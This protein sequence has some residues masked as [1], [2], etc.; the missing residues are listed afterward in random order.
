MMIKAIMNREYGDIKQTILQ[1]THQEGLVGK[2]LPPWGDMMCKQLTNIQ[3]TH[4]PQFIPFLPNASDWSKC[5]GVRR[6]S[7]RCLEGAW[8]LSE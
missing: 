2:T 6:V 1:A 5:E 3:L 4:L 8:G 7:G